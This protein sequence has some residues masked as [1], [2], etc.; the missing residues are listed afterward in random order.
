M[1]K[2]LTPTNYELIPLDDKT[3]V[4]FY[5]SIDTGSYVA[6][7]WHDAIE[8]IYLQEGELTVILE[9]NTQ[10]LKANQCIMIR[11][12]M[13]H[14]TLCTK[15]N[16]AVVFQIPEAFIERFIPDAKTLNFSLRD[17]ADTPVLQGKV[18]MF[19]ETLGKM[20][21]LVDLEPDGAILRFN[22]LLFEI[23]FQLYHNF[24]KPMENTKYLKHNKDLEK[25]KPVLDYIMENYN[26]AISLEEI[27]SVAMLEQKYFCRFFKK[28]MGVTFLEYQS[29]IRLSKIYEDIINT[30]DKISD[31]LERHGF[32]NYKLFRRIFR[33]HFNAT[34]MQIRKNMK[35]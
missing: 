3:N 34:P 9:N 31:I 12:N 4:R 21:L 14:A 33:E 19:K 17:P 29:E 5:T 18:D 13:V 16:R 6:A 11:P 2:I 15:S 25:L 27:A 30:D 7:H 8:I 22:S 20:Q 23:L 24:S 28:M 1:E 10:E 35:H 32:T 26:H